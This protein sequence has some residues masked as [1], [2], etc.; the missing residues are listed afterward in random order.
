VG[1]TPL[2][3]PTAEALLPGKNPGEALLI[4]AGE[5]ARRSDARPIDDFRGSADYRRAMVGVLVK[6]TLEAA[7][8]MAARE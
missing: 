8:R 6:R 2:R 7:C 3:A 4:A 5:A 1:P